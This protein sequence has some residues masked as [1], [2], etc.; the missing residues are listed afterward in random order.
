MV[1][2]SVM[3]VMSISWKASEPRTFEETWPV[4]ATTGM[5]SSIA[6]AM[7]VTRLVAPGPRG[8]HADA[9]AAGGARVAVGHVRGALFVPHEH[10]VDGGELAQ[11]VVDREDGSAGIAEDGG[12][13]FAGERGPEDLGA[14]EGGVVV[15]IGR[16]CVLLRPSS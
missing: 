10:V 2:G 13:A 1:M 7:P 14:G 6:V 12:G 11:R 9:D 8:G 3:P 15:R 4:M 16:H 5:E